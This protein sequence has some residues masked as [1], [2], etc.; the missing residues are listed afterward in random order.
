MKKDSKQD[1]KQDPKLEPLFNFSVNGVTI[2]AILDNRRENADKEF[3]VK[4]RVTYLRDRKYYP[5]GKTMNEANWTKL[6]ATKSKEKKAV[7]DDIQSSFKIIE[8]EIQALFTE[9]GYFSFSDLDARLGRVPSQNVNTAFKA[10]IETL[11]A[12]GRIGSKVF[13]DSTLLNLEAFAGENIPFHAITP[14]FLKRFEKHLTK[15]GRNYTT[16]GMYMRHFRV[17]INEAIRSGT[18]KQSAYPFGK[19]KYEITTGEGRKLALTLSQIKQVITFTDGF[20]ATERYRDLWFFSYLC[21]GANFKDILKLKYSNIKNGEIRFLRAKTV[22]TAKVKKEIVAVVSPEM[23]AIIDRWGNRDR[24]PENHIFPYLTGKETPTQEKVV[25][26]DVT[27]RT[28]KKLKVI[29]EAIGVEHL[30]TYSARHSFATVLKR[31]GS[32]IA[33]ISESLGHAD[34]KTTENYLDSFEKSERLKAAENLTKFE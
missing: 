8:K 26:A 5:T 15:A 14:D 13:F 3:P 28:N 25:I 17:I 12:E 19:D 16:I 10:K 1:P 18:V 32:N 11:E 7:R 6:P 20:E 33:Y 2:A 27:K 34:I 21:N 9:K 29:G 24:K 30:S 31:A 23:K 22:H 4:I